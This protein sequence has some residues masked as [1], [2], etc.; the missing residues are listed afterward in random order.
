MQLDCSKILRKEHTQ[1][2]DCPLNLK[3]LVYFSCQRLLLLLFTFTVSLTILLSLN[4]VSSSFFKQTELQSVFGQPSGLEPTV[5]NSKLKVELVS[6]L[7]DFPTNMAFVGSDDILVLSKNNGEVLRI[8]D[9]NNLGAVLKVN[10]TGKDE[11]GLLGISTDAYKNQNQNQ[12]QNS[13]YVFLCYSLC[14]SEE[15][16][17]NFV[18]KYEWNRNEGKLFNPQLLLKLPGLPGPSHIGGDMTIGPDGYVYLTV[19]DLLT[20]ELFNKNSKYDTQAQNYLGG[21][22]A[23][24]RAGILRFTKEGKPIGNGII[25]DAYP[26][27]LYYAYGI[28]NSFGIGFDPVSE[29]LWDTENGPDFGDEINLVEPGFNSGWSKIQGFWSVNAETS[30]KMDLIQ[31]EPNNLIN[32]GGKGKYLEPKLV[33]DKNVAPTALVFLNSTKLGPEYLND[34]FVG[35]VEEGQIFHLDLSKDRNDLASQNLTED[36]IL[37]E[38]GQED[39]LFASDFGIVTDIQVGPGDGYL[40]VVAGDRPSQSGAIYRI[41]PN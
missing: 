40:Y 20:S 31:G 24:G 8:K 25:G 38:D 29:K 27:N 23:D 19:G 36:K 2:Q 18:Y 14:T 7:P 21:P 17:D 30:E 10:V 37:R 9:G 34:M 26:L 15:Q 12:K 33:W 1:R 16:C 11:M 41:V 22:E 6:S 39:A 4:T 3:M 28:K 32:F 5:M 35:S 13:N